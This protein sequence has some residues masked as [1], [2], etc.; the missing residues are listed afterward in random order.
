MSGVCRI[1]ARLDRITVIS[2]GVYV[3]GGGPL[4]GDGPKKPLENT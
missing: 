3:L 1:S 2:A 4:S